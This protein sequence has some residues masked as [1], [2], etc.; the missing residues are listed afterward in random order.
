MGCAKKITDV[1]PWKIAARVELCT[2]SKLP[3]PGQKTRRVPSRILVMVFGC[4]I[5]PDQAG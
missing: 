1:R 5:S 3:L 2:L 4:K